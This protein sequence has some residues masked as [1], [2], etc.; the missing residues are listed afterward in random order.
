MEFEGLNKHYNKMTGTPN[1]PI[2][3]K[4]RMGVYRTEFVS[5]TQN[6]IKMA[7]TPN[8]LI[9][10]K[11]RPKKSMLNTSKIKRSQNFI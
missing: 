4:I 2:K 8:K 7:G 9:K 3:P 5:W 1:Q 11:I 6:Q 10:S